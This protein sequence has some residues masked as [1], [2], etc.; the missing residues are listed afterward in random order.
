MTTVEPYLI[1]RE[2][3][4]RSGD[5]F[6]SAKVAASRAKILALAAVLWSEPRRRGAEREAASPT[7]VP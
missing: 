5:A 7:I 4:Y 1:E 3:Q 2:L 6:S